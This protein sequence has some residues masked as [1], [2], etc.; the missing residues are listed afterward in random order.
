MSKVNSW[1]GEYPGVHWMGAEEKTAVCDVIDRKT[2]F[3]FWGVD[4]PHYV[5]DLEAKARDYYGCGFALGVGS[6]SGAL[7][8]SLKC[9]DIG[10]GDEV[11]IPSFMWISVVSAIVEQNAIPV[12]CEI[13]DSFTMDPADIERKITPRTKLIVVVHMA[14][15][16]CDMDAI[17][18]LANRRGITVLEDLA[19][20]NGGSYKGRKLGSFGLMS[21]LSYHSNKN[22]TAGEGGL[23]L[24]DDER[25]YKRAVS[26]HGMALLYD[27]DKGEL[28]EPADDCKVWPVGRRMSELA[29]AVAL[30]QFGK[31]DRITAHMRASHQRIEALCAGVDGLSFRRLHDADGNS[32]PFL[33]AVFKDEETTLGA[34]A[35]MKACGMFNVWR[36]QDYGYHVTYQIPLLTKKIPL[37]AAG[38]PWNL[39][40]NAASDYSYAEDTLPVSSD[41]L[42][43]S[44]LIPIPSILTPD[45]EKNAASII[46]ECAAPYSGSN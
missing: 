4:K 45:D 17:M 15:V 36:N 3:R 30:A 42:R 33:V 9:L 6:C 7:D 2:V 27:S 43:R 32:G 10:P 22:I 29:A 19:Q 34:V 18:E 28:V 11:I 23:V 26:C 1:A 39:S 44:V 35:H 20:A 24:T 46:R 38:N 40:E 8:I 16:P 14:G 37:S 31:L 41:L 5:D 12:V 25:L 21:V 13:D